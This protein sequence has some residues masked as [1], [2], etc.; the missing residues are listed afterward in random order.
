MSELIT[1]LTLDVGL[2]TGVVVATLKKPNTIIR[3]AETVKLSEV[4][5]LRQGMSRT[6]DVQM[7]AIWNWLKG[8]REPRVSKIIVEWPLN[9][10]KSNNTAQMSK[11]R[12]FWQ[13]QLN[14]WCAIVPL[15]V[16]Y[17]LPSVWKTTP[18]GSAKIFSA[19]PAPWNEH[20]P[21][22][23]EKDA[24][25]IAYWYMMWGSRKLTN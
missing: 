7:L 21:S 11:V 16:K 25:S 20:K 10:P 3:H 1:V 2:S 13:T 22:Q 15:E 24:A 18:A 5:L 9:D 17:V 8:A 4:E 14:K 6:V 19:Q 23:H 12:E